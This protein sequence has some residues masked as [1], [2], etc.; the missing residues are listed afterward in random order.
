MLRKNNTLPYYKRFIA[1]TVYFIPSSNKKI[2]C[3]I[4]ITI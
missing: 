3:E 4:F 2:A 1:I